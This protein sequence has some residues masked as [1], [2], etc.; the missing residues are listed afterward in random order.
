[1][2]PRISV[3]PLG[4]S[5][6]ERSRR[7]YEALGWTGSSPDG[8]V[9]FIQAG[10]MVLALW[11]RAL[12]AEDSA[13]ADTGGWGGRPLAPNVRPPPAGHARPAPAAA[14]AGPSAPPGGPPP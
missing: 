7:F 9:V 12:L 4:Y 6:F 11:D 1:M 5:D 3:V 14:A 13:V 8:E 2:E 10:S